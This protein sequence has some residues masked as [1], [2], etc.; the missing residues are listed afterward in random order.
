MVQ[1]VVSVIR[2]AAWMAMTVALVCGAS[3]LEAAV[4]WH[5]TLAAAKAASLASQRPVLVIFTAGWSE[6]SDRFVQKTLVAPEAAAIVSSCFE[7]VRLD[8]DTN[9]ELAKRLGVSHLPSGCI[10]D[11]NDAVLAR[12]D[13]PESSAE[14][15]TNAARAIQTS[16]QAKVATTPATQPPAPQA[17]A[18][19]APTAAPA[20]PPVTQ[21][22]ATLASSRF[23]AAEPA[24]APPL[25]ATPPAWPAESASSPLN[26]SPAST[27]RVSA[28]SSAAPASPPSPPAPRQVIEPTTTTT[29]WAS[30]QPQTPAP[31]PTIAAAPPAYQATPGYPATAT[32]PPY[33][34]TPSAPAYPTT[35]SAA[36]Y[37][38]TPAPGSTIAAYPSTAAALPI[39]S[40]TSPA[41]PPVTPPVAPPAATEEKPK[42]TN[43]FVAFFTDPMSLFSSSKTAKDEIAKP[44]TAVTPQP[45]TP[46][47][48][49]VASTTP[50]A[51]ADTYGS[52]P[53]GLE[54]Y[55]P[56][57][58]VDKSVWVEGRPQWGVRHRGRTYLFA[59]P[60]EQQAFLAAPDRYSP[61]LSGDDP[62][63]AFDSGRQVPGQR[64][65][66]VTYQSR[67]YL[68]SSPETR[69]AFTTMP[70]KYA[71]R[72][73]VAENPQAGPG[74][75][76][77]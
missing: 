30:A 13:C 14:F 51:V 2:R 50:A 40:G 37:P 5:D 18:V 23:G 59:G 49:S 36:P 29:P 15:V 71:S 9:G 7:P 57:T 31:S 52:M 6:A 54:G 8:V 16:A 43:P 44:S 41:I 19:T 39:Y 62:V 33:P 25:P 1:R 42:S 26:Q 28:F 47:N 21:P 48:S 66:G 67:I 3:R 10:I 58:L 77:R 53:V 56:V 38:A 32:P 63:L 76:I 73:L 27:G 4:V 20:T 75:F 17:P 61:V 55:C 22:A 46:R 74:T 24:V 65:Y 12:F 34:A 72:V 60:A 35:P 70:E 68:F 69:T 11:Q 64:R 45:A